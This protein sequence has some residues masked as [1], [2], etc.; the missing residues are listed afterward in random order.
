MKFETQMLSKKYL[1]PI[2]HSE[3]M[4]PTAAQIISKRTYTTLKQS[5]VLT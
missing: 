1:Y 5:V 3:I 4:F 2:K